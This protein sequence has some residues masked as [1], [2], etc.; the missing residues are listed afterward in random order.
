MFSV[1]DTFIIIMT[2]DFEIMANLWF[3][4]M[5][6]ILSHYRIGTVILRSK[7]TRPSILEISAE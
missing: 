5:Y 4:S 3:D 6:Q 1:Y 7:Q 2:L